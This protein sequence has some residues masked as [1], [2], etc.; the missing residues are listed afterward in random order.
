MLILPL[1]IIIFKSLFVH[2]KNL[3][4]PAGLQIPAIPN[5]VNSKLDDHGIPFAKQEL[6]LWIFDFISKSSSDKRLWNKVTVS[7]LCFVFI[8]ILNCKMTLFFGICSFSYFLK[9]S[10]GRSFWT[11]TNYCQAIEFSCL[12]KEK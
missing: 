7:I 1:Y 2:V 9:L 5:I 11:T 10:A 4:K 12:V 8:H 6:K 3:K